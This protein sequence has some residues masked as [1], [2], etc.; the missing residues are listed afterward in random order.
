MDVLNIYSSWRGH[1]STGW[2]RAARVNCITLVALS[3]VL[4]VLSSLSLRNGAQKTI[5]FYSGDCDEGNVSHLNT[6]LHFLINVVSTLVLASSNFFMQ[7]LNAPSREEVDAAHA[8]AYWLI[9]GVSSVGNIFRVS[10]FKLWCWVALL[11]SSVP[12]HLL[13]N[14]VVFE[15]DFR[16]SDFH[17]T[18]A[19][20]KFTNGG[21]YFP[22]GA[23]LFLPGILPKEEIEHGKQ[24]THITNL[25]NLISSSETSLG[26]GFPVYLSDY[27]S[28]D[29][30]ETFQNL[31]TIAADSG[32][33]KKLEPSDCKEIYFDC[34]GLKKY[35]DVVLIINHEG[36]I[37]DEMWSIQSFDATFWDVY[38]PSR[39]R[40][41]LFF[42]A[43]CMMYA[44]FNVA[45]E[46]NCV[47][48]CS[49]AMG[50]GSIIHGSPQLTDWNYSFQSDP[51]LRGVDISY[52]SPYW[53]PI[54]FQ[55]LQNGALDLSVD[56]CLAQPLESTCRVGLSPIL[57]LVVTVCVVCKTSAAILATLLLSRQDETPLVTLG[58]AMAT[59]IEKPESITTVY[60]TF[61]QAEI[62][63]VMASHSVFVLSKARKWK[64]VR[65]LRA[66]ALPGYVWVTS[67]LLCVVGI[68]V[69][70][71]LFA[72]A[73]QTHGLTGDFFQSDGN[74]FIPFRFSLLGAVLLANT[75][76]LLLS[77]CYLTYNNL[78]TYLQIA[79][80][81]GKY[82]EGYSSLRVTDPQ[83]HQSSTYRLQLPY[84]YSLPLMGASAILHWILSNTIYV[85]ISIGGYY[86]KNNLVF[87]DQSL[88]DNSAVFVGYSTRALL[89]LT[90]LSIFLTSLPIILSLKQLPPNI[91]IPGC[92]SL[93]ISAACH[94][95]RL[96]NAVKHQDIGDNAIYSR[97]T[98][99]PA[100]ITPMRSNQTRE[101]SNDRLIQDWIETT[102]DGVG[103]NIQEP[104]LFKKLAQSKLRWGVVEMPP[105]W[106]TKF[107]HHSSVGHLSFGVEEDNVSP[108]IE[109]QSYA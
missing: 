8:K 29:R 55:N 57:L 25:F 52:A 11:L 101:E 62:R 67:Y 33:W 5:F 27:Y 72:S 10:R 6:G 94:V 81:W 68:G 83:G 73:Y 53:H 69:C 80:E 16:E 96:S 60:C 54:S 48:I 61:G 107:G 71:S 13:F 46:A 4:L 47:N 108:P 31:S 89:T 21:A 103:R 92:N 56:Y 35:R 28:D 85:F 104:S 106:Y 64:A 77:F 63:K 90:V 37:R 24:Y 97:S 88:P 7:I 105:E 59:F 65:K 70:T 100:P 22:P 79:R 19:T 102:I 36:W 9:I 18:I 43:Q 109:G 23:S 51:V 44:G 49:N 58:D 82:S 99:S 38:V 15:T 78:F 41:N 3:A 14:S 75:P 91:V 98:P 50:S 32:R 2:K 95:S 1:L 66:L 30:S 17:L 74:S 20:E 45:G 93:A 12:I 87:H 76:Q 34:S 86:S 42:D 40:N 26:Y 39:E 84:R